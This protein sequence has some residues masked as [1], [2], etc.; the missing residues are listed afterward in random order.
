MRY[1]SLLFIVL[2]ASTMQAQETT[3]FVSVSDAIALAKQ[4]SYI[5]KNNTQQVV[6]AELTRKAALANIINPKIPTSASLT[7][8]YQ[9]PVNFIPAEVFGGPA[10]A[11]REVTFGQRYIST[12]N[13]SP[14]LDIFNPQNIQK[15]KS[16]KINENL[17]KSNVSINEKA[18]I[19]QVNITYHN[20][21]S[22]KK[23]L[24]LLAKNKQISDSIYTI[25]KNKYNENLARQQDINE[26]EVNTIIIKDKIDQLQLSIDNQLLQLQILCDADKPIQV[27]ESLTNNIENKIDLKANSTQQVNNYLLQKQFNIQELKSSKW[28]QLPTLSLVSSFNWQNNSN[29]KL[30]DANNRWINSNYYGFRL[31]WDLPTNVSKLTQVQTSKIS[32]KTIQNSYQHIVLQTDIQ[33]KQLDNDYLK[34]ISQYSNYLKISTLKKDTYQKYKYQY[35]ESVGS[36]D[37]LLIAQNDW[38][39]SEINTISAQTNIEFIKNKIIVNNQ[40]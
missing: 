10:G 14:Q 17:T 28:S 1:I 12:V 6:L 35:Q 31:S 22:Y 32:L 39:Q 3:I 25:V 11:F 23:Q 15:Y 4:N 5:T 19:D 20:I 18:L 24:E 40:Y 13:I 21:L 30:L 8:N 37:R 2:M 16:A 38:I 36:L 29:K 33:N 26:A 9:L 34:A 7:D 27:L